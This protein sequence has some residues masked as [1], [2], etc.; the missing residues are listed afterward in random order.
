MVSTRIEYVLLIIGLFCGCAI[1][2]LSRVRIIRYVDPYTSVHR[3]RIPR[4]FLDFQDGFFSDVS[5][6]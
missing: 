1:Q 6:V 4:I 3:F 2:T 5:S